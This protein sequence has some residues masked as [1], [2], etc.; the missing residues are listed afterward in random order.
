MVLF[1]RLPRP[2]STQLA[3]RFFDTMN[4][5][6]GQMRDSAADTGI[7]HESQAGLMAQQGNLLM[8]FAKGVATTQ[9]LDEAANIHRS[10]VLRYPQGH[11]ALLSTRADAPMPS[12]EARERFTSME[13][14]FGHHLLG[15]AMV[16]EGHG[17]L[18]TSMRMVMR[19]MTIAFGK[20]HPMKYFASCE[21]GLTWLEAQ[22]GSECQFRPDLALELVKRARGAEARVA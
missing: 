10:L 7:L 4:R 11:L 15:N 1:S 22:S 14:E 19:S 18:A 12:A 5:E 13:Q 21:A 2:R 9:V 6:W 17:V 8:I 16:I 3:F 20:N